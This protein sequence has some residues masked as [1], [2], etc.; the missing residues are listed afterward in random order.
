MPNYPMPQPYI[1]TNECKLLSVIPSPYDD[2]FV[3]VVCYRDSTDNYVVGISRLP[4][5]DQWMSGDYDIPTL[6]EA[7]MIALHRAKVVA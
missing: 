6:S 4:L 3:V 1:E 2:R 5:T 7:I